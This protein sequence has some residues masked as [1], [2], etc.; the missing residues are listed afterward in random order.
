[1]SS[2]IPDFLAFCKENQVPF[3]FIST[4]EYPTDPPGPQS[5]TYFT[6]RLA[7]T[8]A[9]VGNISLYYTEYDCMCRT[10]WHTKTI[11]H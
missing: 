3:D 2:W 7:A 4:H 10:R 5:R 8:R 6:D 9:S 11:T 1:M